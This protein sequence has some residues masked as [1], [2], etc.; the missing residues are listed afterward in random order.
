MIPRR[1]HSQSDSTTSFWGRSMNSNSFL[2]MMGQE[3]SCSYMS[4]WLWLWNVRNG[5][6]SISFWLVFNVIRRIN[7]LWSFTMVMVSWWQPWLLNDSQCSWQIRNGS[8][9]LIILEDSP[10]ALQQEPIVCPTTRASRKNHDLHAVRSYKV[11]Y[12]KW[13]IQSE[14]Y[15]VS[16]K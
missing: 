3:C 13:V 2:V 16:Y 10:Q 12:T 7:R 8:E 14:L 11:I 15:K 5:W 1:R 9:A 4:R 6:L